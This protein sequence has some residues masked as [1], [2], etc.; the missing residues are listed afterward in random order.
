MKILLIYANKNR[1]L[2]PV[3]LG[4][5]MVADSVN[6]LHDVEFMDF[7]F[8]DNPEQKAVRHVQKHQ[9]DLIGISVRIL[10][11]QDSR[12]TQNPIVELKRFIGE[13][14]HVSQAPIVLGGAAFTTFPAEM[15]EFLAADYGIAGQGEKVFPFF[16]TGIKRGMVEES[17]AGLVFRKDGK[18]VKNAAIIEGYPD[19][20]TPASVYY[21]PQ[22]YTRTYWPGIV[23]IKSG[24]PFHCV[25]CDNHITAGREFK[26]RSPEVIVEELEYQV[27]KLN[28]RVFHLSDP[29]FNTPLD[30]AKMVL[31]GII[32][33]NLKIVAMTTCRP[34]NL[35]EELVVLMKRAGIIFVGLGAD[36]LSQTML[37]NYQKGFTIEHVEQSCR[38]LQKGKLGYM[39]E[40]V[41]GGPG[42]TLET[43]EESF[44]FLDKVR[45]SLT[46]L[47]AG[48]RILPDTGLYQIA[49]NE[50]VIQSRS[51]LLFPK[52]Y[53][54]QHIDK[55][56]IYRRI[57]AYNKRYGYRNTRMT[58]VFA[59]K[60]VRLWFG[61]GR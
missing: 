41:F 46:L 45:P 11:S 20:F 2:A 18:V 3:P 16:V 48:L 30:Y 26:L 32:K 51:D 36:T 61:R 22:L 38:L 10:D 15:L 24:C 4:L 33:S 40:C 42:E 43:L 56:D 5:A 52:Y 13:I 21:N 54:S 28:T 47:Y 14:R 37:E 50:G 59:R 39:L 8:E 7:M 60:Y 25:Y 31:E 29:C 58:R 17:L 6:A 19:S 12:S 57:D 53:F 44:N 9:P 55:D 34:G 1:F 35:D 49:L 27:H 23:L